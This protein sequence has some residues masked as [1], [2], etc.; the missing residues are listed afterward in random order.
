M[1]VIKVSVQLI[2]TSHHIRNR[3]CSLSANL[4]YLSKHNHDNNIFISA[5][6]NLKYSTQLQSKAVSLIIPYMRI[7]IMFI[8]DKKIVI[9]FCGVCS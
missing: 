8:S 1:Y 3:F 7:L 5:T 9:W 4:I 2:N 6:C